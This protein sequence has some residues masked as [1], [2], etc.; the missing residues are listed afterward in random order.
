MARWAVVNAT[1]Q[2]VRH[3]FCNDEGF[4]PTSSTTR[5]GL[6]LDSPV[7]F[8]RSDKKRWLNTSTLV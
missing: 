8:W 5:N 1:G 6:L 2:F 3:A 7:R 4:A